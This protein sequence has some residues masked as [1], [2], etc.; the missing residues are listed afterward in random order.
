VYPAGPEPTMITLR[1]CAMSWV[2]SFQW[3]LPAKRS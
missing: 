3:V 2:R 1:C